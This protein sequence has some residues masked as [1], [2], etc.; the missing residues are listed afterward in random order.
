MQFVYS[1]KKQNNTNKEFMWSRMCWKFSLCLFF[2]FFLF[3]IWFFSTLVA[4]AISLPFIFRFLPVSHTND[5]VTHTWCELVTKLPAR[6]I[7]IR[8]CLIQWVVSSIISPNFQLQNL[9][10]L[11]DLAG[12]GWNESLIVDCLKTNMLV[13]ETNYILYK[14]LAGKKMMENEIS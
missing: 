2:F 7:Y 10:L 8:R 6:C 1:H 9:T 14:H 11:L 4:S 13:M 3:Q 12:G 5:L